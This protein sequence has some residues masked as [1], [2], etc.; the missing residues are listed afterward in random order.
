[1]SW[2]ASLG[3]VAGLLLPVPLVL[4]LSSIMLPSPRP[5][6]PGRVP[7]SPVLDIE[8]RARRMTYRRDCLH[9]SDCEPPLGCLT[10]ARRRDQYCID[11]QCRTDEECPEGQA[12]QSLVTHGGPLV[13]F[14]VPVGV[15][16]AGERCVEVSENK[17]GACGPGLVCR[18]EDGWCTRPCRKDDAASCP[19][20]FFCADATPEPVCLPTCVTRGCP[21]GQQCIQYQQGASA[22]ASVY[23]SNCQ[24]SPCIEGRECDVDYSTELPDTVWMECVERCGEEFPPCS[25]GLICDGWQCKPPCDPQGPDVCAKGYRCKQRRPDRPWVCQPD[26]H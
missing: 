1:M 24:Q 10:D 21:E 11:S 5:L 22:C 3:L 12:C 26:P 13:R 16:R 2:R 7:I 18:G 15:R 4:V 6:Q 19:E 23:G 20:G 9:S 14:C 25:V 17:E 8:E